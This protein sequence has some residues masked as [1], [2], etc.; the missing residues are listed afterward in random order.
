MAAGYGYIHRSEWSQFKNF[1][2]FHFWF[3]QN[4]LLDKS[5]TSAT[6][7]DKYC[8]VCLTLTTVQF[9]ILPRSRRTR[10][11]KIKFAE[12]Y[13]YHKTEYIPCTV[14]GCMLYNTTTTDNRPKRTDTYR[15]LRL[16]GRR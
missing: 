14:V 3:M 9:R 4:D 8:G 16:S 1:P 15:T 5:R 12:D 6:L 2:R 11:S 7:H 10:S 13:T